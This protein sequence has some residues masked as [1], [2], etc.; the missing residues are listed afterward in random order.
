MYNILSPLIE[1]PTPPLPNPSRAVHALLT[2]WPLLL[3]TCQCRDKR[4]RLGSWESTATERLRNAAKGVVGEVRRDG[5]RA[6]AAGGAGFG[7]F[8]A[9]F[10][11]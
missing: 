7:G 11:G 3:Q 6:Y 1:K 9:L 8:E 2:L 4:L 5:L 10:H